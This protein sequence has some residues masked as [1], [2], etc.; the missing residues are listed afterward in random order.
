MGF[1]LRGGK[2]DGGGKEMMGMERD[3]GVDVGCIVNYLN[4]D[5]GLF[6]L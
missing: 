4:W 1:W 5:G 2:A 3:G 6:S